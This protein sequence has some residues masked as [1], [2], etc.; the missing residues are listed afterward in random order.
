MANNR[1]L[2]IVLIGWAAFCLFFAAW[3][4]FSWG[5]ITTTQEFDDIGQF[6][7][8]FLAA[9]ACLF[10][11]VRHQGRTRRAWALM[12]ASAFAWGTGQ[13]AWSYYELL[14]GQQVPFPSFADLGYL[15]AVP[16]AIVGVLCFPA[17][18]S[19]VVS[20]ARTILDGLLIAGSLLI[21]SW[22][23][24]LGAVY[25]AGSGGLFGQLIGLAYP[26]GDVVIGTMIVI[27]AVR[28]PRATRLPLYLLAG[29]LVAN[30]LADSGFAYLTATN[31]YGA[32]S[33]IDVGWAAG[34]LLI[35]IAALR[36]ASMP[37]LSSGADGPPGRLG[38]LLPYLPVAAGAMVAAI[39]EAGPG[40]LDPVVFWSLLAIIVLVVVRQFLTLSDNLALNRRLEA[41]AAELAKGHEHFRSLVQNSSDVITLVGRDGVIRYQSASV[42]RILGYSEDALV[43]K[44]FGDFIHADDRIHMLRKIDEAINIMGPP[45][46][47][48]CRL[49][50][51]DDSYCAAEVTI[52]NLLE[53]PSVRGLVLNTRD[54]SERKAL[55]EK[56]IHQAFHD[57]LTDLPNRAA[58]RIHLDHALQGD[59]ERG[60]AV[61]FLDL[62][63]FK[64]VNDTLGHDMGDK[65]LVAVAARIASTL[66]PGDTVARLGGDE[67]AVLL[68]NMEDEKIASRVAERITRQFVTPFGIDGKEISMRASIGIAGV[69]SGQEAAEELIR[70]ADVAMYIAKSKGK[71]RYVEYDASLAG[72]ALQ[73]LELES[74]MHRALS[75]KQFVLQYQP[76]VMLESGAV[77][78]VEA[79]VRWNHPERGLLDL[80]DFIS[81]A[82]HNG[83]I[84]ELGRWVL[85]QAARDGRRWQVRYPS[86]PPMGIS[87]NL[88]GRQLQHPELVSEVMD[89]VDAAG[90]DPQSLILELTES[91]MMADTESVARM[92][93]EFRGRGFRLAL[94]NFGSAYASLGR[95]RDFPV[96]I[97]KIDASFV[98]G[99]GQ[100]LTDGAILRAI[101]GLANSLGLMTIGDG[102]ER[103][104]QLAA[105]NAMGCHAGQ[106]VFLSKPLD[107]EGMEA[108][109]ALC[110]QSGSGRQLPPTWRLTA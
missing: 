70:N 84:V 71:A 107:F 77:H 17:A 39:E 43:G 8:A 31:R 22:S 109:L 82:E 54:V 83:M 104:E 47:L 50:R 73:L 18:P 88:Y 11:A 76:V 92:L 100:G 80:A 108:L 85:Q 34:Y 6:V 5:G 4:L 48:E 66:R 1:R 25:R 106:G 30:L 28:V 15:T 69:V 41:N 60:I 13:V 32:G 86:T 9:A 55:E 65:L 56:L 33:V 45:I 61:L 97:L 81:V 16:L 64:A 90:L 49:R 89:A 35:A 99:I 110:I 59:R 87:V 94:D 53:L 58:F 20:L 44:P 78:S 93:Q 95:L 105:L 103:S 21:I 57:S 40:E 96:D 51:D 12:A 10:T 37:A 102:I 2:L 29:G 27:L 101:I 72:A 79:L 74:E 14:K 36:A 62:D 91:V 42:E 98:A 67:F 46:A 38:L 52:T 19:R 75:E 24:V 3:L 26:A 63:D 7:I 68:K 23:T